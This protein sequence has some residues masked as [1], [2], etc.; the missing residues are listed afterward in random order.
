MTDSAGY[1][2]A[3]PMP[4]FYIIDY[5]YNLIMALGFLGVCVKEFDTTAT[6]DVLSPWGA[7]LV[8]S[9]PQ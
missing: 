4:Q 9:I 6:Q 8:Y 3:T 2:K 5:M 7:Q 1:N